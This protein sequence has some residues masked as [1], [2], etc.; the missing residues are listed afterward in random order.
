MNYNQVAYR[1][2]SEIVSLSAFWGHVFPLLSTFS[3]S[4]WGLT[5][6]GCLG[7]WGG[8][9]ERNCSRLTTA[10]YR[11]G[12]AST[13]PLRNSRQISLLLI[14]LLLQVLHFVAFST[15]PSHYHS[16]RFS[17]V[18]T[19]VEISYLLMSQTTLDL[20]FYTLPPLCQFNEMLN[21]RE[22]QGAFNPP[23]SIRL[24]SWF[25]FP[26][27]RTYTVFHVTVSVTDLFYNCCIIF[28]IPSRRCEMVY[29]TYPLLLDV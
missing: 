18:R 17:R 26:T 7:E 9:W 4:G 11:L 24:K 8:V 19:F 28:C 21:V 13:E 10:F 22:G 27:P 1:I 2:V 5:P 6:C 20:G 12:P 23:C 15:L 14:G 3:S 25:F 29:L 16:E